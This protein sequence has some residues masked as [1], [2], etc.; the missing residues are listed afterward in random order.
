MART[1]R[2]KSDNPKEYRVALRLTE[3]EYFTLKD[4]AVKD[5]LT[6]A[7]VFRKSIEMMLGSNL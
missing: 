3:K 6:V 4:I 7:Q 2:P 1:G 5:N